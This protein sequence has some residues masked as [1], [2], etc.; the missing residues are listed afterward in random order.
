MIY[1]KKYPDGEGARRGIRDGFDR[2]GEV[3]C[4]GCF[5]KK[6][7]IDKLRAENKALKQKLRFRESSAQEGFFGSSTSSSKILLKKNSNLL[8]TMKKGGAKKGHKGHGRKLFC[9]STVDKVIELEMPPACGD[10]GFALIMRDKSERT[11]IDVN[12]ARAETILYKIKEGICPGCSKRHMQKPEA[13]PRSLYSNRLLAQAA[14]MH[15]FHGL[16][17]G[18]VI[19]ILGGNVNQSG[20]TAAFHR[21]GAMC[22]RSQEQLIHDFR[23][24]P[25]KHADETGWRNDGQ[26]GYAWLFCSLR[27]SIFQFHPTRSARIAHQVFGAEPLAGVLVVDRYHAYNKLPCK[28]QYCFAHLLRDVE[29]LEDEF[30]EDLEVLAFVASFAPLL[31]EAMRLRNQKISNEQYYGR[32]RELE[33]AI[34][35]ISAQSAKHPGIQRIQDIFIE[36]EQRLYHWVTDRDVPPENNFAERELRPTVIARKISYG[37]QSVKGAQTRGHIMTMLHTAKKRIKNMPPE[38]WLTE[39]LNSFISRPKNEHHIML[40]PMDES[41]RLH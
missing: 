6:L 29:K 32:A 30:P 15:Y 26:S 12:S 7:E 40:P 14:V 37:S 28:I 2:K 11:V 39:I 19:E 9:E 17:L 35:K 36:K 22:E 16:S 25:V 27:T 21:L 10:C 18:K 20:L 3:I 41:T 24:A 8:N 23:C 1:E 31:S 5:D 33:V 13:L 34:K 38:D 4:K